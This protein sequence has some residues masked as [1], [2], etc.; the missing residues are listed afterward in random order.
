MT[1]KQEAIRLVHRLNEEKLYRA[2][3][4]LS[5]LANEKQPCFEEKTFIP[6]MSSTELLKELEYLQAES[7]KYPIEDFDKAREI[8]FSI[9]GTTLVNSNP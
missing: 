2:I 7:S 5:D 1:K 6:S 9:K 3:E 4:I 8:A